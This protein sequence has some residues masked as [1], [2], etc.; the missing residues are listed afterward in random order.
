M[1]GQGVGVGPPV[2]TS[3]AIWAGMRAKPKK[4]TRMVTA[5]AWW[6]WGGLVYPKEGGQRG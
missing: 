2:V 5:L 3:C 4:I 1:R 6:G